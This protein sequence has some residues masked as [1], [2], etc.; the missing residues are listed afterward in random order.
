MRAFEATT[1]AF[2]AGALAGAGS[3]RC[4]RCEFA[5]SLHEQDQLPPCPRCGGAVF[6][7]A[8]LFGESAASEPWGGGS[9]EEPGW[10][11]EARDA[12]VGAGDYLAFHDDERLRVIPLQDGWTRLGRSLAA[13]IRFDDPTVSRRHAMIHREDDEVRVLDDR[14]LNGLFVNGERV[15]WHGLDDGD[16]LLIG[17]FRIYFI[18]LAGDVAGER[19]RRLGSAAR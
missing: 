6:R 11:E 2:R 12:L 8:S 1:Q 9:S 17:R 3:F 7:R 19:G 14:S 4:E 10:L 13:H 15:D 16:E 18:R 5:V